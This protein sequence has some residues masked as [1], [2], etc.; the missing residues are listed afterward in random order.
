VEEGRKN[1]RRGNDYGGIS[2]MIH[3]I[4]IKINSKVLLMVATIPFLL[5]TSCDYKSEKEKIKEVQ[6]LTK[7]V[8]P[9][10]VVW[11]NVEIQYWMEHT[12][13]CS[14]TIDKKDIPLL[15]E[16]IETTEEIV[17]SKKD[18]YLMDKRHQGNWF[19]P[20]DIN[21][22]KAMKIRYPNRHSVLKVLYDD[23]V[24]EES[25]KVL[26]YMIWFELS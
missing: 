24:K 6:R 2:E 21:D 13:F 26:V 23:S 8:F 3:R 5:L 1:W 14:F 12:V 19:T 22:F 9:D 25:E 15:F 17:W 16:K 20:G 7:M 4:I 11:I 10:S 18:R